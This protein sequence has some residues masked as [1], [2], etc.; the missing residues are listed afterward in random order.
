LISQFRQWSAEN[1][2]AVA[3]FA[4]AVK[5]PSKKSTAGTT[6]PSFRDSNASTGHSRFIFWRQHLENDVRA[7]RSNL[8][9]T[10]TPP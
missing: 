3:Q 2:M 10:I 7:I 8:E 6:S 9:F 1:K 4:S 5:I